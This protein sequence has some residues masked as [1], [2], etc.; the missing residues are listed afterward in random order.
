MPVTYRPVELDD[1]V[2]A[3]DIMTASYPQ[4]A[5]DPVMTR[6]RWD[7]PRRGFAYGRFIAET[8]GKPIAF[9]G[10]VHGSWEEVEDGHCEV[11]VWLERSALDRDL[12]IE[13][14]TWIGGQA[15]AEGSRILLS[16]CAE[17]EAEMLAAH[18]A[19]G[20][21][22][23]R[24]ERVWQLDLKAHGARLTGGAAE[25]RDRMA[26]AGIEWTSLAEWHD[27]DRIKKLHELN[28]RT[29]QDVP[30]TL[31]IVREALEDFEKRAGAP[32]RPPDRLWIA[33]DGDRPV[34]MSY[35]KFP[36][37]RGPVWTGYTC[38]DPEYRGQGLARAIKL[39]TLAQAVELGVPSV[40]TSNDGENAPMLHINETLGYER[41][42][43][44]V[45]HHKRVTRNQDA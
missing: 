10:W 21:R 9:L 22:R 37:V 36:P 43:G 4:L 31:T 27:P 30:H 16:Y 2:L 41:R 7:S 11:E 35:L 39:Q 33:L 34:A 18:A 3:A 24:V 13:M 6:M 45:E 42:P 5:Q 19:L 12:L 17:D 14:F 29:V 1:A 8:N 44:F 23:E 25:A 15:E 32:D 20:Y 26:A 28:E 38:S 40:L